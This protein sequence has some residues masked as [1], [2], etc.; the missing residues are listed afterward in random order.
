MS[1]HSV[2]ELHLSCAGLGDAIT[3]LYAACGLAETGRRVRYYHRFPDWLARFS[4]PG[5]EYGP[6]APGPD[7]PAPGVDMN[8]HYPVQLLTGADR[9]QWYCDAVSRALELPA[10]VPAA[11]R[12][13]NRSTS[14]WTKR[15]YVLLSP[16]SA[17]DCRSWPLHHWLRLAELLSKAN[18]D[19]L[20]TCLPRQK[21]QLV[22]VF[23]PKNCHPR[24][25][26]VRWDLEPD[27][28]EQA[29]LAAACVAG[30]DSGIPHVSGLFGIPTVAI[31][32]HLSRELVWSRT[33]V[34]AVTP[35][36]LCSP[37]SWSRPRGFTDSCELRCTALATISPER[38]LDTIGDLLNPP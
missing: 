32:A 29:I 1:A 9:K 7:T 19:V 12:E 24:W 14:W 15:P 13:I 38:V 18:L 35:Q 22:R 37:C 5:V 27:E 10:F 25:L 8:W 28:M 26:K 30:N 21:K 33:G 2:T 23:G 20:V 4:H 34:V 6:Q 16:F 36:T 31:Q 17:H 3:G 11:P